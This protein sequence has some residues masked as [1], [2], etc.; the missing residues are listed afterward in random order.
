MRYILFT[1][2]ESFVDEVDLIEK[3][4]ANDVDYL[5]VQKP[6]MNDRALERFLLSIPEGIRM[7]TFFCGSPSVA[8][9]FSLA[10][11]HQ[12]V[13][14]YVRNGDAARRAPG[15]LSV[16]AE[17]LGDLEKLSP[18]VRSKIFQVIV[19]NKPEE[20]P[21]NAFVVC[22]ATELPQDVPNRA[23]LSGIWEFADPVSAWGRL[24]LK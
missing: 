9:E 12:P 3:I 14:W 21:E 17:C 15:L 10:G 2:V 23:I 5:Y 13:E 6:Y 8:Q 16:E 20:I 18:E 22:D 19:K 7:K 24:C 11:F 4:F 1:S